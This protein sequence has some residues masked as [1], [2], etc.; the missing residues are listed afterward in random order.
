MDQYFKRYKHFKFRVAGVLA[1]MFISTPKTLMKKIEIY[2]LYR[3]K[4]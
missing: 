3:V 4:S 1:K 2:T